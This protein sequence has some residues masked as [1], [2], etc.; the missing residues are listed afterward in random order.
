MLLDDLLLYCHLVS[1]SSPKVSMPKRVVALRVAWVGIEGGIYVLPSCPSLVSR[2]MTLDR[3]T[4]NEM[5]LTLTL[6]I[7]FKFTS[8]ESF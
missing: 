6:A 3:E 1:V 7:L 4:L 5:M 8:L 2:R